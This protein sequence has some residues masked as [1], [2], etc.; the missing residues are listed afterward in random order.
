MKLDLRFALPVLCCWVVLAAVII[1]F[2]GHPHTMLNVCIGVFA[3]TVITG[4]LSHKRA[5]V[6][7][8]TCGVIAA[9][10]LSMI[11]QLPE[12]VETKPW[13]QAA[14]QVVLSTDW[15]AELRQQLL[16]SSRGLPG[17]GGQLVPGMAVGDTSA[18][19]T[20]LNEAMKTVSLSHITA[21][22]GANCIIVTA[23]VSLLAGL[24]GAGRRIR[25]LSGVVALVFFV[26]LVTPQPSVLRA[27]VM[28]LVVL[29]SIYFGRPGSGIPILSCAVLLIL[30]W[31]PW[32]AIE[33]GFI[34][35]ALAVSG[36]LLFSKPLA[37][38]LTR[39]MPRMLA[40]II[41]IPLAAQLMCQPVLILL[42]PT[43]PVF[44]LLA[45]IVAAPAAPVAT[46]CGLCA[47]LLLPIVPAVGQLFLWC[48]WIPAQWIGTTAETLSHLP[49]ASIQWVD[50]VWGVALAMALSFL[51][52][53]SLLSKTARLRRAAFICLTLSS[54]CI[55]VS[56]FLPRFSNASLPPDWNIAACDVGQGDA[57]ILKSKTAIAA[58]DV[59]RRP[60][61]LTRCMSMLGITHL[62][63]LVLTHFDKD[64]VG[65]LASVVGKVDHVISGPPE[66]S[67]DES[68]L[69]DLR[70]HG[71]EV[72]R[73][74]RG[75]SGT[76]GS[77]RWNILWP[78]VARSNMQMGNP[79]SVTLAVSFPG[80]SSLF[81]GDLGEDSQRALLSEGAIG[82]TDVVKVA[83]HGSADQYAGLY[84]H[85]RPH[86]SLLSVGAEND[87]GHPRAETMELLT[88]VG[89]VTPRTD[90]DGLVLISRKGNGLSVWTEH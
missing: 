25:I 34:L 77:A 5:P 4:L 70:S 40:D 12:H 69:S 11:L 73:G 42:N 31:N 33:Y 32:W 60:A 47:C 76:L 19:S 8:L 68:L 83:H 82:H 72:E 7:A 15:A 10:C 53:L 64:H 80:F 9:G 38:S 28:A 51:V 58:I 67:E 27:A 88:S 21:V 63:L 2:N 20:S 49:S 30:L 45:N 50:G 43:V 78:D 46:V 89:S 18:V 36:L 57:L 6:L 52:F 22:S 79:G 17:V 3:A 54:V 59:G 35:S 26:V 87:Y 74:K 81:L 86:I 71:A 75:M 62:D 66:N 84:E 16:N 44:G 56:W 90:H 39:W 1:V 65:G 48:A 29:L 13:A 85:L 55:L 41:S 14:H 37:D 24:C 61:L 23:G